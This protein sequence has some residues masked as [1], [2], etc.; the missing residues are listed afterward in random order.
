MLD[1]TKVNDY[2]G[3]SLASNAT[4]ETILPSDYL[5]LLNCIC[6]YDV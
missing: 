3:L 6:I 5:H 1:V 2:I 4:Y